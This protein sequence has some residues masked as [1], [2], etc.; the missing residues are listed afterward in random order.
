MIDSIIDEIVSLKL[1]EK[2]QQNDDI[3]SMIENSLKE[4]EEYSF[5]SSEIGKYNYLVGYYK[6]IKDE[7][8][9][10]KNEQILNDLLIKRDTIYDKFINNNKK[11]EV[12][13]C[14]ICK[15]T[16][17]IDGKKCQCYKDLYNETINNFLEAPPLVDLELKPVKGLEKQ[18]EILKEYVEKFPNLK[19]SN[20]IFTGGTGTG[21][22][23]LAKYSAYNI[24][25]KGYSSAF[26]SCTKI[27]NL[28]FKIHRNL[29]DADIIY[30]LLTEIDF[31]I[32]D[33]LGI[34]PIFNNIT[35]EYIHSIISYRLENNK[36]FI[37]TTNLSAKEI[38]DRYDERLFSRLMDK[39]KTRFIDFG[40][41]DLRIKG[42]DL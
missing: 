32:I 17:F 41:N 39:D 10:K 29:K 8:E 31:L 18:Y 40:I 12:F 19:I 6:F 4:N 11:Y 33:D 36:P 37:I 35:I 42:K 1:R 5:L 21:K 16:G 22:T 34:E 3:K 14:P 30:N 20:F 24:Q 9:L 13:S 7:K 27:N 23:Y 2:R 26:I 25:K 38:K 15:D 28:L